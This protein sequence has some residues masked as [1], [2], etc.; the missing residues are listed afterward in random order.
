MGILD[1]LTANVPGNRARMLCVHGAQGVGKTTFAAGFPK[2]AILPTETGYRDIGIDMVFPLQTSYAS[3][4][5]TIME[6]YAE[7]ELPFKTLVLDSADWIEPL[8]ETDLDNEGFKRDFGRGQAECGQRFKRILDGLS[9]LCKDRGIMIV[10]ISH[11]KLVKIELPSGGSFDQWQPKLSK[12]ANEYLLESVDEI[13][14]VHMET[15][16]RKESGGFGSERGVG[17]QTGRR[18]LSLAPSAAYVAKNRAKAGT[19]VPQSVELNFESYAE[20]FFNN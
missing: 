16:V 1:K 3:L 19:V 11:S 17:L 4:L 18:L 8:I 2:P 12:K 5:G 7:P 20:L 9:M 6:L 13:G 14:F 15:V 10:I